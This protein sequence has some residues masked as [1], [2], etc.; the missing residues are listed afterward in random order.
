MTSP[1]QRIR[2]GNSSVFSGVEGDLNPVRQSQE[3]F[4]KPASARE[5]F[6]QT[7]EAGPFEFKG[8]P[9]GVD[10]ISIEPLNTVEAIN[11]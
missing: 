1:A 2:P 8:F 10:R 11:G 5:R 9:Y 3:N 4:P 7:G 6:H